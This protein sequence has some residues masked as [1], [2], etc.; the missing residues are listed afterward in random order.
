MWTGILPAPTIATSPCRC[1][2]PVKTASRLRLL[3]ALLAVAVVVGL[4]S[5][6]LRDARAARAAHA[7]PARAGDRRRARRARRRPRARPTREGRGRRVRRALA[8]RHA[9]CTSAPTAARARCGSTCASRTAPSRRRRARPGDV[10]F[11]DT[12]ADRRAIPIATTS[13]IT[14]A[15]SRASSPTAASSSSRR[16]A[17]R[18]GAASS[19]RCIRPCGATTAARSRTASC[20]RSSSPIRPNARYFAGQ[21]L[22][23]VARA[24]R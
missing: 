19:I 15:S 24:D 13:P 5:L 17:A 6:R 3:E 11:F 10:L 9:G 12:R 23:G 1:R 8:A 4:C 18:C 14:P 21:M 16:A 22:C 7:P 2:C 20:A